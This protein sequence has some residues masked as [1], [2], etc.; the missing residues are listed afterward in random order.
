M[1]FRR[2]SCSSTIA[3]L[4]GILALLA[5]FSNAGAAIDE[6]SFSSHIKEVLLLKRE[7]IRAEILAQRLMDQKDP[8]QPPLLI[9]D[10]REPEDF[11]AGHIPGAISIPL[12]DLPA[13]LEGGELLGDKEVVIASYDGGDGM[14]AALL[15][16]LIRV[17]S[18]AAQGEALSKDAKTPY[19]TATSLFAGMES[20][21]LFIS[22]PKGRFDNALGCSR[23]ERPVETSPNNVAE[24]YPLPGLQSMKEISSFKGLILNRAREYFLKFKNQQEVTSDGVEVANESISGKKS[25]IFSVRKG[26]HYLLGHIPGAVSAPSNL[27]LEPDYL[28]LIDP[29]RE[30]KVYCYTGMNGGMAAMAL[31]LL[32]YKARNIKYGINGW[33][34]SEKSISGHLQHFDLKWGWDFPLEKGSQMGGPL[35]E[36]FEEPVGCEGC[37]GDLTALSLAVTAPSPDGK[38]KKKQRI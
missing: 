36:A 23:V 13:A 16:D 2:G 24:R 33:T 37:H 17:E 29:V 1:I 14:M 19:P 28:A 20:W 15:I 25:Q 3:L 38:M 4:L 35:W 7:P 11:S 26:F 22:T 6:E 21:S 5:S 12:F 32:G 34:L 10:T 27:L 30:V 31:G 9:I 8:N 18:P